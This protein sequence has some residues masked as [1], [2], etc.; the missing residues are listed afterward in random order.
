MIPADLVR[1]FFF[2]Y[3]IVPAALTLATGILI[4]MVLP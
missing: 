3:V 1:V 4:G 2:F